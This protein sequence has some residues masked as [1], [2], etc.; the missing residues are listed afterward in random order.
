MIP[1]GGNLA[2]QYLHTGY[3]KIIRNTNLRSE[4]CAMDQIGAEGYNFY[5]IDFF[6]GTLC[7]NQSH[8]ISV[9]QWAICAIHTVIS[10][11]W[12]LKK[13]GHSNFASIIARDSNST[14]ICKRR[15]IFQPLCIIGRDPRSYS[16]VVNK[17]IT[18]DFYRD[19]PVLVIDSIRKKFNQYL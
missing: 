12:T 17:T 7:C 13:W 11:D 5:I 1:R 4:Q 15:E 19:C 8:C 18:M 16:I 14:Y 9:M 3:K 6:A 10:L 2:T